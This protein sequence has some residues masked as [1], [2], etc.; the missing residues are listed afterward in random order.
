MED[1]SAVQKV[2]PEGSSMAALADPGWR[3][4]SQRTDGTCRPVLRRAW[5]LPF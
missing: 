4:Q 3:Y 5:L 2:L 1:A